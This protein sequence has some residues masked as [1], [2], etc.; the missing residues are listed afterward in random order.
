MNNEESDDAHFEYLVQDVLSSG[1]LIP[2]TTCEVS[3]V[4][5]KELTFL[6]RKYSN[7]HETKI[8]YFWLDY[9]PFN[10]NRGLGFTSKEQLYKCVKHFLRQSWLRHIKVIKWKRHL[11]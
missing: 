1:P 6:R 10:N 4:D 9:E 2:K 8:K 5:Y 7:G 3:K 11:K